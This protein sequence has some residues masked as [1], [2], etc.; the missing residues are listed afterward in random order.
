[1][2]PLTAL[3]LVCF[4]G[5]IISLPTRAANVCWIDKVEKTRSGVAMHFMQRRFVNVKHVNGDT[6]RVFV[7]PAAAADDSRAQVMLEVELGDNVYSSN[8]P[9]DGC[10]MKVVMKDEKIGIQA[11]AS[12]CLLASLTGKCDEASVFIEAQ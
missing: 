2:K 9:E 1:M 3:S 6:R 12:N 8:L 11:N 7:D 5:L 4:L 10:S